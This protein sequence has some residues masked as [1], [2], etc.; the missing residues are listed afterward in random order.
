SLKRMEMLTRRLEQNLLELKTNVTLV[1][2]ERTFMVS[3]KIPDLDLSEVAYI[4]DHGYG[5]IC[6][7]GLHCAP[8]IHQYIGTGSSGS[9][10]FSVS[11]FTTEKDIDYT[12]NAVREIIHGTG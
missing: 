12:I 11:R 1:E 4:L 10:R 3:F 7:A 2:G 8:L 6:R 9:I 5:I